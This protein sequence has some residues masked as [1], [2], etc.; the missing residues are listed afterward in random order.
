ML[1]TNV[2]DDSVRFDGAA[3]F[4]NLHCGTAWPMQISLRRERKGTRVFLGNWATEWGNRGLLTVVKGRKKS[5]HGKSGFCTS[6]PDCGQLQA[7]LSI[8]CL[9]WSLLPLLNCW[10]PCSTAGGTPTLAHCSLSAHNPL[11]PASLHPSST[12]HTQAFKDYITPKVY[13][14]W[15]SKKME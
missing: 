14:L 13:Q 3:P 7:D 2:S 8:S 10:R 5:L 12:T 9:G 4:A 11:L 6:V 15:M 1:S